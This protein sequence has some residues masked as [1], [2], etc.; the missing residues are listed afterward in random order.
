MEV[1][2]NDYLNSAIKS[3]LK[4]P[5]AKAAL[6]NDWRQ[7]FSEHFKLTSEENADL[8]KGILVPTDRIEQIQKAIINV[9][10][11]GGEIKFRGVNPRLLVIRPA[12]PHASATCTWDPH[13]EGPRA[14]HICT[15]KF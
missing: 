12:A 6:E 5:P 4:D 15:A 1:P 2:T 13:P 10:K 3:A 9:V 11:F 14:Y 7:F 8:L